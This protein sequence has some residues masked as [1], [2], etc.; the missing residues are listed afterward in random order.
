MAASGCCSLAGGVLGGTGDPVRAVPHG[1]RGGHAPPPASGA[2]RTSTATSVCLRA[3]SPRPLQG[4]VLLLLMLS[5][6]GG[7]FEGRGERGMNPDCFTQGCGVIFL[8]RVCVRWV[9]WM[10]RGR[11]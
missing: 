4:F 10:R 11:G 7:G 3:I 5:S 9:C 8:G 2:P 1:Q 6:G